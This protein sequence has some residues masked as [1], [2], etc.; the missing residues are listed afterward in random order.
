MIMARIDIINLLIFFQLFL[1]FLLLILLPDLH[2]RLVVDSVLL[3][4][5]NEAS[6]V[7]V[8]LFLLF[9]EFRP[10]NLLLSYSFLGFFG[11]WRIFLNLPKCVFHFGIASLQKCKIVTNKY[12]HVILLVV[13]IT[14]DFQH[15]K[16]VVFWDQREKFSLDRIIRL[17]YGPELFFS[18]I[19]YNVVNQF[20]QNCKTLDELIGFIYV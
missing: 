17:L 1:G 19:S 3:S 2:E 20:L 8:L 4:E 5:I 14:E 11:L 15:L 16:Q 6:L 7:I 12:E 9:E 10:I 18:R 13:H